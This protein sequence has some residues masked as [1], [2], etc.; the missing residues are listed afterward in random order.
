MMLIPGGFDVPNR[1]RQLRTTRI[2]VSQKDTMYNG[3]AMSLLSCG[4]KKLMLK[5]QGRLNWNI[6]KHL[7]RFSFSAPA[8]SA[9][10]PHPPKRL[11]VSVYPPSPSANRPFFSA[12]LQ[13]FTFPPALPFNNAWMPSYFST[14]TIPPL[15]AAISAPADAWIEEEEH[16]EAIIAAGT[17][18]WCESQVA[19]KTNKARGCWV[20]VHSP[21]DEE[22]A[23][24][25]WPQGPTWKPWAVGLWLED[26][27]LLCNESKTWKQ[28][29]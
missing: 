15:P 26:A 25:W 10:N 2:Y 13:P 9:E 3:M 11:E 8:V 12:T 5:H 21:A 18:D 16:A 1:R 19:I 4:Y 14:Q 27:T 28:A 20:T 22:E 24:K 17:D 29:E 23:K 7:A 6:P